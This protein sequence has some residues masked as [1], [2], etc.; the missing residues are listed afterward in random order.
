MAE[1][2]VAL[3]TDYSGAPMLI[4]VPK[5]GS[6]NEALGMAMDG[7]LARP[8][9]DWSIIELPDRPMVRST[10][11]DKI[12]RDACQD[13]INKGLRIQAIKEVRVITGWGLKDAK[14]WVDETFPHPGPIDSKEPNKPKMC[15]SAARYREL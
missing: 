1:Y 8:I 11:L 15:W 5:A 7:A 3:M 6:R 14:T 13:S 2:V 9:N 12:L 4:H 10:A